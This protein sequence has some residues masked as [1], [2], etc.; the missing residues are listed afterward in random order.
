MLIML[1]YVMR[2]SLQCWI[3]WMIPSLYLS[4]HR[5]IRF[6]YVA[7]CLTSSFFSFSLQT[8]QISQGTIYSHQEQIV[9]LIA[10]PDAH[11]ALAQ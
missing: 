6:Q 3:W 8:H 5:D 4:P 9:S 2:N 11:V 1:Y 7:T 10:V